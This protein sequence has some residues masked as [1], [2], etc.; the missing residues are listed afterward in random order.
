MDFVDQAEEEGDDPLPNPE[1]GCG[2]LKPGKA[3]LRGIAGTGEGTLPPFVRCDPFVPYREL[4]TDES[5]TRGYLTFDGV[6]TQLAIEDQLTHFT[7]EY[8]GDDRDEEAVENLVKAGVYENPDDAPDLESQRHIDRIRHRNFESPDHWGEV[9]VAT[10]TDL[11]MRVGKTHYPDPEKFIEEAVK[12]GVSKAVSISPNSCP[13]VVT[14]VTRLWLVHP[15]TDRGWAV[16]GYSY[17]SEIVYTKP[18]DD[19]VPDYIQEYEETG[20]VSVREIS[21]PEKNDE[22][23]GLDEFNGDDV[24]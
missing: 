11:M 7:R 15:D 18:E 22:N 24:S 4:P 17:L 3:Y 2:H 8:H 14:G 13:Q 6:T 16:I 19:L 1:R 9:E 12:H 23:L 21:E 10:Q 5:F 20:D